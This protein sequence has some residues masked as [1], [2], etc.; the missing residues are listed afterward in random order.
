MENVGPPT[1]QVLEANWA[2]NS[3]GAEGQFGLQFA[4]CWRPIWASNQPGAGGQLGLQFARCWRP[5]WASNP[6]GAG[7]QLGLQSTRCWR[8]IG[9][10]I[11]LVLEVDSAF[12]PPVAGGQLGFKSTRCWRPILGKTLKEIFAFWLTKVKSKSTLL[13]LQLRNQV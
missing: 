3:P 6:T 8:P 11:H 1:H 13:S 10:P 2:S 5:N 9:P 7:G 4:R 12:N